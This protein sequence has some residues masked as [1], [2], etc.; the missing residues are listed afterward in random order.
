MAA[1]SNHTLAIDVLGDHG[2]TRLRIELKLGLVTLGREQWASSDSSKR[3]SRKQLEVSCS[4][5]DSVLVRT[6]GKNASYLV[7]TDSHADNARR[8]NP[9]QEAVCLVGSTLW[10]LYPT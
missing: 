7:P 4:G 6:V 3:C 5:H 2:E 10:L 8:I 1:G 9:G